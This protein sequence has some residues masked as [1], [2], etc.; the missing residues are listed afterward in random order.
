MVEKTI[1]LPAPD[2]RGRRSLES[3]LEAR[4]SVREFTREP[5]TDRELSQLLWSAQ[6]VT[7]AAGGRTA[8]SAGALYPLELYVATPDGFYHYEPERHRLSPLSDRDRRRAIYRS[9]LR[10]EAIRD[11]AAVFVIA[12]VYRRTTGKY[13]A[14]QGLRYVHMDAA[15][16]AQN[17]LLQAVALDLGAVPIGAFHEAEVQQAVGLTEH[18]PLYLVAVG[19]PR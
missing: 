5:L 8:P 13:G 3:V 9:A 6:G 12:A 16:C 4:R 17:L 2:R 15:H 18:E 11:A 7:D 1:K 19:R 14:K 10:Q